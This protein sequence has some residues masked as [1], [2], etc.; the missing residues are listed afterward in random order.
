MKLLVLV[1]CKCNTHGKHGEMKTDGAK[2]ARGSFL[3][4]YYQ[5]Y[6]PNAFEILSHF[7]LIWIITQL[8]KA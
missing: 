7:C 2:R 8:R 1:A 3:V 5:N 4:N 6:N